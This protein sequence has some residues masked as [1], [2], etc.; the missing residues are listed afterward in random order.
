MTL[1]TQI[2]LK[3]KI[4]YNSLS[5]TDLGYRWGCA[6]LLFCKSYAENCIKMKGILLRGGTHPCHFGSA[7]AN[8]VMS[9]LD[10]VKRIVYEKGV[11]NFTFEP[12][13]LYQMCLCP[14]HLT[15]CTM[16]FVLATINKKYK[17]RLCPSLFTSLVMCTEFPLRPHQCAGNDNKGG[18]NFQKYR[19][20]ANAIFYSIFTG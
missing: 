18:R 20:S 15:I 14:S 17:T 6:N 8:D 16:S 13:H 10:C 5:V 4:M 3:F 1:K 9:N 7:T 2:R 12:S 19:R 11:K